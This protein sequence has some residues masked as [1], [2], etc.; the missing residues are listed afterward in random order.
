M[1]RVLN[2]QR[3]LCRVAV[4][5]FMLAALPT[6]A[7]DVLRAEN[8]YGTVV[9]LFGEPCALATGWL[10]LYRAEMFYKGKL[11]AACWTLVGQVVLVFDEAGDVSPHSWTVF[12]KEESS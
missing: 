5:A 10:K 12:S 1:N 8:Q 9:R 11:Y 3:A 7:A 6:F 2:L 4:L